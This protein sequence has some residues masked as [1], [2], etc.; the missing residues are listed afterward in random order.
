M[1]YTSDYDGKK[2]SS[3]VSDK[4][5]FKKHR[6]K[7]YQMLSR[8]DLRNWLY[9][10]QVVCIRAHA[11]LPSSMAV[12]PLDFTGEPAFITF[13][14]RDESSLFFDKRVLMQ[15]SEYFCHM[16][17]DAAWQEG[18]T[19]EIDLSNN[20]HANSSSMSAILGF[21]I[22]ERT[23]QGDVQS[24]VSVRKLGDQFCLT[25]LVSQIDRAGS[26]ALCKQ[27][28]YCFGPRSQQWR[29]AG[30]EVHGHAT[31]KQMQR[32]GAPPRAPQSDGKEA[33]AADV[34]GG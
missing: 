31:S 23:P 8:Q 13:R 34:D 25:A 29:A 4:F 10:G 2:W 27:R 18:R 17:S 30:N 28:A 19:N 9:D 20:A 26:N 33:A 32:P 5:R 6:E 11:K 15:R 24:L 21:L 22:T 14:L 3:K 12:K 16:L 7:G 1:S